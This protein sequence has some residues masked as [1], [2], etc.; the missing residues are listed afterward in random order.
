[1][2]LQEDTEDFLNDIFQVFVQDGFEILECLNSINLRL[3][4]ILCGSKIIVQ[5]K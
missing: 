1:M 5:R 2:I 3:F 4:A